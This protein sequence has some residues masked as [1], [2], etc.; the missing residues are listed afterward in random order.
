MKADDSPKSIAIDNWQENA[1][2]PLLTH[3]SI[4]RRNFLSD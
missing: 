1:N 3:L 4:L 2:D